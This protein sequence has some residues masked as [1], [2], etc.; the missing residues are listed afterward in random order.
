MTDASRVLR[1]REGLPDNTVSQILED[2]I[3]RLWLG[4]SR[5]IACVSKRRLEDVAAGKSSSLYPQ[6]FGR[7]DGMLSEE[8]TGGFGPAGLKTRSGLLWFSTMKGVTVVDPRIQPAPILPAPKPILEEVL[9]DGN[10]NAISRT[11]NPTNV[12]GAG[13]N[14]TLEMLRIIPGKHRIEFRYTAP[15]FDASE[16][17]RFRY[18]LEGL[19]TDWVDAGTRRRRLSTAICRPAITI[20]TSTPATLTAFGPIVNRGWI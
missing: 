16:L 12:S 17:I 18:R 6:V 4:T 19:D 7:A 11:W 10:P 5:G 8:C 20:S 15:S 14:S 1:L 3:G 9:V 2:N 13:D